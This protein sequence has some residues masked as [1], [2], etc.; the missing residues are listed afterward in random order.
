MSCSKQLSNMRLLSDFPASDPSCSS[1]Q[2]R[3]ER[4]LK[5][6]VRTRREG[7]WSPAGGRNG[8]YDFTSVRP[9]VRPFFSETMRAIFLIFCTDLYFNKTKKV[10]FLFFPKKILI[11]RLRGIN[12]QKSSFL[13]I[14]S[15]R[16]VRFC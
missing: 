6:P 1:S 15:K 11:P 14:T 10:T 7:F 16:Y 8:T 9:S 3:G 5:S 13:A 2:K 12:L 4:T